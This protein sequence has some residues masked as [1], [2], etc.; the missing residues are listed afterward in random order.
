MTEQATAMGKHLRSGFHAVYIFVVTAGLLGC[1]KPPIEPRYAPGVGRAGTITV[2]SRFFTDGSRIPVDYTCDGTDVMPELTLSSPPEH[3][4]SLLIYVEDPDAAAGTF[5]HMIAFNLSPEL[6]KL[7]SAPDLST[8]GEAARFGLNDF[9]AARYSGPCPPKGEAH[10]YRFR[11]VALDT[12]LKLG[13]GT[14]R[15][16]VDE[17]TDTHIL[18]E[19]SL[20]GHFGH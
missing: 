10:R 1:A 2:T 11:V 17:A 13:E 15:S 16:Q 4:K 5:T 6:R 12:M 18:G 3:T 7:P 14:P 19:G 9:G 20:T 8:G